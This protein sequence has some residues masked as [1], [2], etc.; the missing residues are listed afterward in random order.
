MAK[1]GKKYEAG[2]YTVDDTNLYINRGLG[3]HIWRVRFL[4]RPEITIFEIA[5]KK[6]S[7]D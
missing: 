4:A 6:T 3:S 1:H 7:T 5:P 2:M